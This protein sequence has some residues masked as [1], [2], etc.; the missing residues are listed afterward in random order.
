MLYQLELRSNLPWNT[1]YIVLNLPLGSLFSANNSKV[2]GTNRSTDFFSLLLEFL[3]Q[4]M[5]VA[6]FRMLDQ[7]KRTGFSAPQQFEPVSFT[8]VYRSFLKNKRG[9]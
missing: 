8:V 1:M 3:L 4:H 7:H 9:K 5:Q 6:M 2:D